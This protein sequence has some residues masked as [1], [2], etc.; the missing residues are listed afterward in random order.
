[1][2]TLTITKELLATGLKQEQAEA[3]AYNITR[4]VDE[5]NKELV[6]KA[7]IRRLEWMIGF[8][9]VAGGAGFAYMLNQID[10][11]IS[12]LNTIIGKI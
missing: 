6:T 1:M 3:I 9:V 2:D 12:L 4:A 7:D 5:K 11:I 8:I 10:N